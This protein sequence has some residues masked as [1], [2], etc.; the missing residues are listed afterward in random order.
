MKYRFDKSTGNLAP[1][2]QKA[3]EHR[4]EMFDKSKP[5]GEGH[6]RLIDG[7]W[8][9][10]GGDNGI[11]NVRQCQ[12]TQIIKDIEPYKPVAADKHTGQRPIIG[13]RRQ[14]REFLRNNGYVEIGNDYVKPKRE[15]LPKS[16]R[17]ADIKRAMNTL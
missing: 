6:W 7:E 2:S 13:G 5:L 12:G 1:V 10:V 14:H 8:V 16:D 9:P 15:E 3:D 17:I 4:S 11:S